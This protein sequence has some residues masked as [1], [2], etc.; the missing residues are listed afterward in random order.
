[1]AVSKAKKATGTYKAHRER[2]RRRILEAASKLFDGRG[3]DGVTMAEITSA[4]GVQPSTM[5]QYFSSK[6]DIVW[7]IVGELME[8]RSG[9][10]KQTMRD[11]PNALGRITALLEMM[12]DD[13]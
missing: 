12:A 3:I 7:A 1:M 8:E 4:S 11:A 13:L 10:A 6:D 9:L 5:Y 2:Q